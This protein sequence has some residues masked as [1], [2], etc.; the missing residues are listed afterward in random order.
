MKS[1]LLSQARAYKRSATI[2]RI[3]L[4]GYSL[5]FAFGALCAGFARDDMMNLAG[6]WHRGFG[7]TLRD[8][9]TFWTAAYRPVGGLF[10]LPI[11]YIF[12]LNPLPYRIAILAIVCINIQLA[13]S[14]AMSLTRSWE[15]ASL[16]SVVFCAHA[17]LAD[18]YYSN[19]SIYDVLAYFFSI[20]ALLSYISVRSAGKEYRGVVAGTG[21]LLLVAALGAKEIAI[22]NA[23]LVL[24]YE[25]LFNG[26]PRSLNSFKLWARHQGRFPLLWVA[27]GVIY[28]IGKLSGHDS[29]ARTDAYHVTL[30]WHQYLTNNTVY[31]ASLLR[32]SYFRGWRLAL[33]V[34]FCSVYCWRVRL[35]SLRWCW[36][37]AAIVTIPISF[38]PTRG[39]PSL[40]FL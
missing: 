32:N 3:V 39:G 16:A 31:V 19:S 20:V 14:L 7:P 29:L 40:Y 21:T 25:V 38:I 5:L 10:Y 28:T 34:V 8:C 24:A 15:I 37:F 27:L 4:G 22:Y 30:S 35:P 13:F 2:A 18:I 36:V 26:F 1:A 33:L 6:Y 17:S 11:Y 9:L 12:G 23:S